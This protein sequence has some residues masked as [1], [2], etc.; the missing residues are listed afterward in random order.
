MGCHNKNNV[1]VKS[2][3]FSR[4]RSDANTTPPTITYPFNTIYESYGNECVFE[5]IQLSPGRSNSNLYGLPLT[6]HLNNDIHKTQPKE[7]TQVTDVVDEFPMRNPL[8]EDVASSIQNIDPEN[9]IML[10]S[11]A[12]QVK[13][14]S[15]DSDQI[16]EHLSTSPHSNP[17]EMKSEI[18][19][20]HNQMPS[21]VLSD[22][23]RDCNHRQEMS[24]QID[25][26]TDIHSGGT[27]SNNCIP[28]DNNDDNN[29]SN[30]HYNTYNLLCGSA[31]V[32]GYY[33]PSHY[34]NFGPMATFGDPD[35]HSSIV[36]M[37]IH[38]H[39][40][41][42]HSQYHTITS[43]VPPLVGSVPHHLHQNG[44]SFYAHNW[45]SQSLQVSPNWSKQLK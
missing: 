9:A 25:P 35:T 24:I 5:K 10:G 2:E 42:Q 6:Y 41:I 13:L 7:Y 14:E 39:T 23:S 15:R 19:L 45:Q 1:D 28:I 21:T 8:W 44:N 16:F 36:A 29:N 26:Q 4:S 20:V 18:K 32:L 30:S 27:S 34:D 17:I 40:Q 12:T 37:Q 38:Q 33:E 22:P 31:S 3:I 11:I 43:T